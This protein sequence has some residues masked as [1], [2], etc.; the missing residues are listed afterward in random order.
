MSKERIRDPGV[1]QFACFSF[2]SRSILGEKVNG[3]EEKDTG[4]LNMK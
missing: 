2:R 3:F 4:T 1:L